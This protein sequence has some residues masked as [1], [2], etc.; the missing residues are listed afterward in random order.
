MF[1]PTLAR[2]TAVLTLALGGVSTAEEPALELPLLWEDNLHTFLESAC[3]AADLDGDGVDDILS[4]GREEMIA[5]SGAGRELWR[6]RTAGRFMTYPTV[7][8]VGGKPHIYA[9]DNSGLMTCLDARGGVVWQAKLEAGTAWSATAAAD[10]DG[11]GSP[12]VVQ[13]DEKGSVW[14]FDG[15]T[16]AVLWKT[17]VDGIPVSPAVGVLEAGG[18]P[19]VVVATGTGILAA[20]G[21]DGNLLWTYTLRGASPSWATSA[22]VVFAG[23]AGP[24]VVAASSEGRLVCLDGH[25]AVQWERPTRGA[26]AS[27]ISVADF[28][29]DGLAD[30]FAITQLGTIHRFDETGRVLWDIDMQGRTLAPGAVAD[31]DGDGALEFILCTQSGHMMVLNHAGATVFSFQFDT[32]TINVTPAF[33]EFDPKRPGLEFAVTGGESG[34]LFCFGTPGAASPQWAMYR[35]DAANL[36]AWPSG[37]TSRSQGQEAALMAPRNLQWDALCAG[38]AA[39]FDILRPPF[40]GKAYTATATCTRPDGARQ[41]STTRVLG[42]KGRLNLPLEVLTPGVYQFTWTLTD[43][44]GKTVASGERALTLIPFAADNATAART[45]DELDA[46]ARAVEATLP[47]SA[48]ALRR[49]ASLLA[50]TAA[51]ARARQEAAPGGGTAREQEALATTAKVTTQARRLLEVVEAVKLAAAQGANT[52]LLVTEGPLWESR[53]VGDRVPTS[54]TVPAAR[55]VAPGEHE[56]VA[57]NLFNVTDAEVLVRVVTH[58]EEGGPRVTVLQSVAVPTAAGNVAWDAM[59]ALDEGAVLTVPSLTTREV[60]IDADFAGVSP[61]PHD[62]TVRLLALTGAGVVGVAPN[63]Q[64]IPVPETVVQ[65]QYQV[66]PFEMAGPGAYRMCTWAAPEG[67][68]VDDLLAHGNNVFTAP[69]PEAQY[70]ASGR[71]TRANYAKLDPILERMKGHDVVLMLSHHPA[72]RPEMGTPEYAAEL[73]Q[74]LDEL[75]DH[76]AEAGV[77]TNHFA[78]YPFDE[79]GGYGWAVVNKLVAFGKAVKSVR[80]DVMVYVNGGGEL[81]MFEAMSACTDIWSPSIYQLPE[82]SPEMKVMKTTGK[83][84]WSY[85]CSYGYARPAGPNIKDINV[86]AEFRNAAL[87]A[88]RYGATG[89]GFWC[90]NTGGDPWTRVK[91]EYMLV[92]P[93]RDKPVTSRRWEAVREGIEDYRILDALRRRRHDASLSEEVRSRIAALEDEALPGLVDQS[94]EEM[95]QGFGRDAI[96]LTNSEEAVTGFRARLMAAV[97]DVVRR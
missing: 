88:M 70:D 14:C 45:L 77:D 54:L 52:S 15:A 43:D 10:L 18:R 80:P 97:E 8:M 33:G 71:L 81:P 93:G 2:W 96:D 53:G 29:H 92:Y 59:P 46:T 34:R 62:V 86:V 63:P 56:P 27:A 89:G 61:G 20:I 17:G 67:A 57:L 50:S 16:G 28:D 24:R 82:A 41:A 72:L 49:E 64:D 58:V 7:A 25:G 36:A 21:A 78:L 69:L 76:M 35:A 83:M 94:F 13:T 90:Y 51:T 95:R 66:L 42:A 3:V 79:P 39:T 23:A 55:V 4:A 75:V 60:W 74:Y 38:D 37:S 73:K 9:A 91:D 6:W 26:P 11:D 65:L 19:A 44:E 31:L 84:L 5:Y 48:A 85:N 22:P 1:F 68:Q 87:F 32:R 30:I 47:R 40:N 12:E